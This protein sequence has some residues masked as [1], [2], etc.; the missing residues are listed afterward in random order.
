MPRT[1]K[2][3]RRKRTNRSTYPRG[4]PA[5]KEASHATLISKIR[6]TRSWIIAAV[7]AGPGLSITGAVVSLTHVTAGW[8]G[9]VTGIGHNNT[10][11]ASNNVST[12]AIG[13]VLSVEV[14]QGFN[15]DSCGG[16]GYG[17]V[18]P[19]SASAVI[20]T[21]PAKGPTR[22]GQTWVSD[23]SAWGAVEASAVVVHMVASGNSQRAIVLTGLKVH[24]LRRRPALQG[25]LVDTRPLPQIPCAAL[26]LFPYVV[27]ASYPEPFI[28]AITTNHCDCTWTLELDWVEGSTNG[29]S[30]ITDNGKPFETTAAADLP[31]IEWGY[32]GS[33]GPWQRIP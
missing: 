24:I 33:D 32:G 10:T 17:W 6:A 9:D 5:R 14:T 29:K 7:V 28:F 15:L 4:S 31:A 23:P 12:T 3:T 1:S 20:A 11:P 19:K 25:T 30:I 8:F 18:F 2:K 26:V 22:D 13:P 27:S 16:G 21:N